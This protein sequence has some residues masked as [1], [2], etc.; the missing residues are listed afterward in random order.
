M[1]KKL[2]RS[3]T[4][5]TGAAAVAVI[6]GAMVLIIS[7]P[8]S[9]TPEFAKETGKTCG[10]CHT[11]PKGGGALTVFGEKFKANGNKMPQ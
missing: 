3:F 6:S 11:N 5:A 2:T 7:L 4:I 8:A 1:Q 10:E 9:A